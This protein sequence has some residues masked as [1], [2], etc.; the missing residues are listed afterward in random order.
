MSETSERDP[1]T[2]PY[3]RTAV[4]GAMTSVQASMSL[5]VLMLAAIAPAVAKS[6]DI[7]AALIGYQVSI[8]FGSASVFS[9]I[10]GGLV[11]RWGA[12]RTSQ[13]ALILGLAGCALATIPDIAAL[14]AASVCIGAGYA[15]TNPSASHLLGRFAGNRY[16]NVIFSIKQTGV[17][18]GGAIA[19]LVAPGLAITF[20]WQS[21]PIA[22]AATLLALLVAL[23]ARRRFWDDD[24]DQSWRIRGNLF[25]G[26]ILVWNRKPLRR[27][28]SASFFYTITQLCLVTFLVTLLVEDAG[29]T[30][31]A[32]GFV[33]SIV[34]MASVLGRLAWGW[35]AD[36][37]GD[38][39]VVLAVI[40]VIA[41]ITSGITMLVGPEWPVNGMKVLFVIFG[42]AAVGWNGV[43]IAEVA[44]V[45]P[46]G[47]I[48]PTT[49]AA[50]AITFAGVIF[51]P[52]LF[53]FAHGFIGSYTTTFGLLTVASVAGALLALSCRQK[54]AEDAA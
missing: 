38:G 32:A 3:N 41:G 51:G 19:G 24:R 54:N 1:A 31:V 16:R 9:L 53:A 52:S 46:A 44:R 37:V 6:L 7:P 23:Q 47:R 11:R 25:E 13:S 20:G 40:G 4:V 18:L 14:A 30:L 29:M 26:L 17:P 49:G 27:L 42:I 36:K 10:A 28:V 21:V 22:A 34:Q 50:L 5:A 48:G 45:S 2:L 35:V 15:L 12:C 43:F 8:V 33:L 39:A